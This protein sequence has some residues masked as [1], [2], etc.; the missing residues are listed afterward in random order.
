ML[1]FVLHTGVHVHAERS[2]HQFIVLHTSV[3]CDK[4]LESQIKISITH[5]YYI[6]Y[7]KFIT[8]TDILYIY[9]HY[10]IFID[11]YS[12]PIMIIIYGYSEYDIDRYSY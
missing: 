2:T 4:K 6:Y 12:N 3:N 11:F 8:I 9:I 5:I 10:I 7:Y 1:L